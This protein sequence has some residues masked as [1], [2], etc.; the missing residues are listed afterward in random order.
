MF[1]YYNGA[2]SDPLF[3]FRLF[4]RTLLLYYIYYILYILYI[5][6]IYISWLAGND[7]MVIYYPY[8]PKVNMLSTFTKC[9]FV[10]P[11]L[12]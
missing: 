10:G 2:I 9:P 12:P 4:T 5:I 6:Y 3:T 8:I 11:S 7:S 1:T